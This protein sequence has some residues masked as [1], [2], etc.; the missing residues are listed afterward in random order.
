MGL[1]GSISY[2]PQLQA[3]LIPPGFVGVTEPV[4]LALGA[5]S[6]SVFSLELRQTLYNPALRTDVNT[7]INAEA[8]ERERKRGQD[9]DVK[10]QVSQ[11]YLNVQLRRLQHQ[12]A[13]HEERRFQDYFT[14]AEGRYQNG[15]LIENDYLR[16]RLGYENARQ[17]AIS[18]QQSYDLSLLTLRY[19]VNLPADT[20]LTL[21]DTLGVSTPGASTPE[22]FPQPLRS[23]PDTAAFA[24]RTELRQLELERRANALQERQQRQAVAPIISLVGNYSQQY[25]NAS[26]NYNYAD[27]KWWSPFNYIGLQ[28]ALPIT[29]Q[30]TNRTAMQQAQLRSLQTHQRQQQQKISVAYEIQYATDQFNQATQDLGRTKSSY[31]LAQRVYASQQQQLALGAFS[32][33][34]LLN[35]ETTL[36]TA[37]Q[38]YITALYDYLLAQLNY[39]VATGTL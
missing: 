7:A 25:L 21:T 20:K 12:I 8:L 27:G 16:A 34:Q 3:T 6:I 32:Y 26:F 35:T 5:K 33:D 14:L 19:Q 1:T 29:G 13:L 10:R 18:S 24:N 39:Q 30:F 15:V 9:I 37:E 36:I 23:L 22:A 2:H 38:N 17:Q 28:V 4:V 31:E 11:A